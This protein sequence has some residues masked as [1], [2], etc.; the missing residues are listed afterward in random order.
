MSS[1]KSNATSRDGAEEGKREEV[2]EEEEDEGKS[3]SISE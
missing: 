3:C 1:S 2:E